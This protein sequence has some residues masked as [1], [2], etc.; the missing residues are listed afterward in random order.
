MPRT[1]EEKRK[2]QQIDA[3]CNGCGQTFS[4]FLQQMEQHNAKVVVCPSCGKVHD[5]SHPAK[6]VKA[7]ARKR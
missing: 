7:P 5:Y 1:R 6:T 3:L 4:A 2:S